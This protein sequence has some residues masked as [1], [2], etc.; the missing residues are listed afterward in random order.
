VQ[1]WATHGERP[2]GLGHGRERTREPPPDYG[3]GSGASTMGP[4]L[5]ATGISG[6]GWRP[7]LT[8]DRFTYSA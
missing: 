6:R 5:N 7:G 8:V 3:A 2:L 1:D 4:I